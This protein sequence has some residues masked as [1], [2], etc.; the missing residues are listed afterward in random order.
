M[1]A[2]VS[3]NRLEDLGFKV[4]TLGPSNF[5]AWKDY[6]GEDLEDLQQQFALF[7]ESPLVEGWTPAGL[8]T[9][10]LLLEGFPLDSTLAPQPQFSHNAVFLATSPTV[11][12]R[13]WAC[14]DATLHPDTL[15][16]LSLTAEDVF[17]CLDSALDDNAKLRLSQ[18][19]TLKTI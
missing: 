11:G 1:K 13:L 16:A 14:F 15:T 10:V 7:D 17:V 19:C 5:R 9:E 6:K 18:F 2:K 8:L 4:L 3:S 12:H